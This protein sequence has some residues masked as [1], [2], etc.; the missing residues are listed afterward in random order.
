M[1]QNNNKYSASIK[2]GTDTWCYIITDD[3]N[4]LKQSII[5]SVV[6]SK[7]KWPDDY[8]KIISE[9]IPQTEIEQLKK[10]ALKLCEKYNNK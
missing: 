6:M 9:D 10:Q 8:I 2:S 7:L 5:D 3:L 4:H 1:T